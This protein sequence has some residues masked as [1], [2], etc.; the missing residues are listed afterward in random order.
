M[1]RYA[2]KNLAKVQLEEST[3]FPEEIMFL[4]QINPKVSMTYIMLVYFIK[5]NGECRIPIE[6][7]LIRTKVSLKKLEEELNLLSREKLIDWEYSSD[8]FISI[9]FLP[10]G[11]LKAD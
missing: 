8:E 1:K 2:N 11:E 3:V 6:E 5:A 9:Y 4:P 10:I 7:L